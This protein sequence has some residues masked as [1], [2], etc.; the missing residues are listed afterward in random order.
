[1]NVTKI[2]TVPTFRLACNITIM[3]IIIPL[4]TK[5][6]N[7]PKS[8]IQFYPCH[9][10]AETKYLVYLRELVVVITG[11]LILTQTLVAAEICLLQN[12]TSTKSSQ[13][14]TLRFCKTNFTQ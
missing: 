11:I 1:M 14:E 6:S 4:T 10:M 12:L 3:T 8:F 13:S 7:K 5:A 9:T 2:N